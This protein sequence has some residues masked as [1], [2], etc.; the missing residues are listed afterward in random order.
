MQSCVDLGKKDSGIVKR[1]KKRSINTEISVIL[2]ESFLIWTY[3][4]D[5]TLG[6]QRVT[7]KLPI[8]CGTSG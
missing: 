7:D 4:K 5:T 1:K 2:S 8:T 6:A 3:R